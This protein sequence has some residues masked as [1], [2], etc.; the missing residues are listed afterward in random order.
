MGSHLHFWIS[1]NFGAA[2]WKLRESKVFFKE[3]QQSLSTILLYKL[4]SD[5]FSKSF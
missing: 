5:F 4:I 1:N 3:P 2:I